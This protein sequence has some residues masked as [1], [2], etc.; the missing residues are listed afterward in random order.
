MRKAA[1][2]SG[3]NWLFESCVTIGGGLLQTF[4]HPTISQTL[5]QT[6]LKTAIDVYR[7]AV[8]HFMLKES[9]YEEF[10]L[11]FLMCYMQCFDCVEA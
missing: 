11:I 8:A 4:I 6:E 10:N 1:F 3:P 9:H 5:P 2:L 7:G